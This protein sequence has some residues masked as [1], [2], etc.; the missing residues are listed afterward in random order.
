[1]HPPYMHEAASQP[2]SGSSVVDTV[3]SSSLSPSSTGISLALCLHDDE[4]RADAL[5][6]LLAAVSDLTR[7]R[8]SLEI[9][10][11]EAGSLRL[12]T[13]CARLL[14]GDAP[15]LPLSAKARV[16]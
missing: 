6:L 11:S 12:S 9:R 3:G 13:S 1:M 14:R 7:D 10:S 2:A 4:A 15:G 16:P 5:T 8:N